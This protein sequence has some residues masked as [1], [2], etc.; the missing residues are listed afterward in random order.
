LGPTR[1]AVSEAMAVIPIATV[2]Y[3]RLMTDPVLGG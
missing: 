3:G 2:R 1:H